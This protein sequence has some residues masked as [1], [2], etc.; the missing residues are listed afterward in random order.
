MFSLRP[1]GRSFT[2]SALASEAPSWASGTLQELF[3]LALI[4][5]QFRLQVPHRRAQSAI[6]RQVTARVAVSHWAYNSHGKRSLVPVS[7]LVLPMPKA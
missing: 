4:L 7:H 3:C 2:V 6:P 5:S 1:W